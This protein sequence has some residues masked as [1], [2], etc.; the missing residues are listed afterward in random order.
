LG[1]LTRIASQEIEDVVVDVLE[2]PAMEE[3]GVWTSSHPLERGLAARAVARA[4]GVSLLECDDDVGVVRVD[5]GVRN[6]SQSARRTGS[7]ESEESRK[8]LRPNG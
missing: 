6:S 3:H 2:D 7:D 4:H 5:V 8:R 1:D